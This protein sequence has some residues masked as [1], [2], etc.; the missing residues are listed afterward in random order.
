MVEVAPV[1]RNCRRACHDGR[2]LRAL[3]NAILAPYAAGHSYETYLRQGMS[4][5]EE[6]CRMLAGEPYGHEVTKLALAIMV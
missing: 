1:S 3:P 5:V 2:Q 6:V 4:A